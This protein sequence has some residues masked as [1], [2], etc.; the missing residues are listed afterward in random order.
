MS[1]AA[2]TAIIMGS[3]LITLILGLPVAVCLFANAVLFTL[4]FVG[5][6]G[7]YT[8]FAQS[9]RMLT[10]A[11]LLVRS[12]PGTNHIAWQLGHAIAGTHEML[13]A[14]GH[15]APALPEGFAEAHG[16][17]TAAS[18][19]PAKFLKKAEYL[20]LAERMKA[21]AVAA[22]SARMSAHPR[23]R[24]RPRTPALRSAE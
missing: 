3:F 11:N 13:A 21:A 2:T 9:F 7:L 5:Q 8:V 12:V 16:K 20:A 1:V 18:N 17:A 4:I 15:Q 19:D 24:C 10:D 6:A 22:V 14:L 23:C